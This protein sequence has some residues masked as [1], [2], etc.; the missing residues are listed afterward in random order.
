MLSLL[1][2]LSFTLLNTVA[3]S[4][5]CEELLRYHLFVVTHLNEQCQQAGDVLL[6]SPELRKGSPIK[7]D[8]LDVI[9]P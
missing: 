7:E 5:K 9:S 2:S 3:S 8:E 4:L 1:M 6:K